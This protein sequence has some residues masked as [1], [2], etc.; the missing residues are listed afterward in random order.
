MNPLVEPEQFQAWKGHRLTEPFLA[1]LRDRQ[2]ALMEA[3][4][5]GQALPL[6][7]Q[8]KASLLGE[9]AS[10]SCEQVRD[11]YQVNEETDGVEH[12]G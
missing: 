6:E 11:F 12:G 7:Y 4:G 5:R 3:W 1:Y 9:L 2:M 8:A 10:L